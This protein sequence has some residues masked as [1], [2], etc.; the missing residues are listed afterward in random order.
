MN[1]NLLIIKQ[2]IEK[3]LPNFTGRIVLDMLQGE[4]GA[5]EKTEKKRYALKNKNP[6]VQ[7]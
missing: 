4:V 3:N 1:D 2:I 6:E 5:I 7:H